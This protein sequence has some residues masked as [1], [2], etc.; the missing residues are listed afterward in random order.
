MSIRDWFLAKKRAAGLAEENRKLKERVKKAETYWSALHKEV[1]DLKTALA[2]RENKIATLR[3]SVVSQLMLI[4]QK[5]GRRLIKKHDVSVTAT[6]FND[7][8]GDFFIKGLHIVAGPKFVIQAFCF[9]AGILK[10]ENFWANL[11]ANWEERLRAAVKGNYGV[12]FS[13]DYH[14]LGGKL[15]AK[16]HC[17]ACQGHKKGEKSGE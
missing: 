3:A 13:D 6:G 1:A 7:D 11:P 12:L 4:A 16:S 5:A 8:K 10:E 2:D 14:E 17:M 15:T 9:F